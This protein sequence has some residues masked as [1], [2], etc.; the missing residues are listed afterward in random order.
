MNTSLKF[1]KYKLQIRS[2]FYKKFHNSSFY[3]ACSGIYSEGLD[4]MPLILP[5]LEN[6]VPLQV[7]CKSLA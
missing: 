2:L 3:T 7:V 1:L 6:E 4:G 5:L